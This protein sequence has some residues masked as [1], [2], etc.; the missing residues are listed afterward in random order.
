[1]NLHTDFL[2]L[3]WILHQVRRDLQSKVAQRSG[4]AKKNFF[5]LSTCLELILLFQPIFTLMLL[6]VHLTF[7]LPRFLKRAELRAMEFQGSYDMQHF[8]Q[9]IPNVPT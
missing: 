5:F 1:M 4:F 7:Y 2:Y 9:N 8:L 6:L 3:D